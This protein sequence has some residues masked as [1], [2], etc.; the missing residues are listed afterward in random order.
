MDKEKL[1][2]VLNQRANLRSVDD[3]ALRRILQLVSVDDKKNLRCVDRRLKC[4]VEVLDRDI[5]ILTA[6]KVLQLNLHSPFF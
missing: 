4:R 1:R 6:R 2:V 5:N 3:E